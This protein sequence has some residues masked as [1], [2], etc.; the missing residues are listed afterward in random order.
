ME[1]DRKQTETEKDEYF[2][3]FNS[4]P[5]TRILTHLH[6]HTH[7]RTR[8]RVSLS[9]GPCNGPSWA[10]SR[11]LARP[12]DTST[13]SPWS[14]GELTSHLSSC[15]LFVLS[16]RA[17][18]TCAL[19]SCYHIVLSLRAITSCSHFVLSTRAHRTHAYRLGRHAR[20]R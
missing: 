6:E 8:T 12:S 14:T 3:S 20:G 13:A 4:H 10:S 11:A 19:T 7:G 5:Y 16:P 15:S 9:Q 1:K 2:Q 18:I 17:I